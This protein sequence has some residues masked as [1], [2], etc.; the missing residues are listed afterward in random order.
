MQG[1]INDH[2][3]RNLKEADPYRQG[4]IECCYQLFYEL[5][6]TVSNRK[7][8]QGLSHF[9]L[10]LRTSASKK[11]LNWPDESA[12]LLVLMR[13]VLACLHAEANICIMCH[14]KTFVF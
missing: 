12:D 5:G 9:L 6:P 14:C 3:N 13:N 1:N 4:E 7:L 10:D 8:R 2:N 11:P